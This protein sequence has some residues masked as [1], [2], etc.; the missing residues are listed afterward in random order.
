MAMT[1]LSSVKRVQPRGR[2]LA[3]VLTATLMLLVAPAGAWVD[4]GEEA[5]GP[6]NPHGGYVTDGSFFMSVGELQ[7]NIT[8]WGLIG[9]R[10]SNAATYSDAP[11]AQ[12]PAGSG[13]EY[14]WGAGLWVGGV[15]L[16]E[17]LV[18]T[19]QYE[20][21]IRAQDNVEDTIYEAIGSV[22]TRPFGFPDASGRRAP[23]PAPNDD[24]DTDDLGVPR[25]DEEILNGYDDDEDG[26]LEEDFG[27]VG[28]Q[29]MVTTMYDNTR[30]AAEIFAD[31]SPLNLRI[32]QESFAWENDLVDDFV[33]FQYTIT[34]VG[35]TDIRNVYI[36]FFADPDI[37]PRSL[38]ATASDDMAGSFA[39][40]IKASDGSWVP[41]EVGFMWDAAEEQRLDGYFGIAFL[42][43]DVDPSGQTAPQTIGLRT[44]QRFSGQAPFAQ[45]GDPT[46]DAERYEL[47]SADRED[48]DQDV[49]E[50]RQDDF[51]FL[52][53]AGPFETLSPN[54]ELKFQ[55]AIVLGPG[56]DGMLRN[57]AEAALT[58]YG[59]FFDVL[60]DQA[61]SDG[62]VIETG[63]NGRESII[64][65]ED[66]GDPEDF[67]AIYPDFGDQSCASFQYLQEWPTIQPED[68]FLTTVG[69]QIKH[70]AMV[71]MDNCF[72]CFRQKPHSPNEQPE[73]ARCDE[74]DLDT[75]WNCWDD[76]VGDSQKAGCT[77]VGGAETQVH[78]LVGMAPPPPGMRLWPT[79]S[80]VHVYWD[81]TSESIPDVRLRVIDFESY[82]V[83]RAD[84]WTRPFGTS[85]ETGPGSNLWQLIAEYDIVDSFIVNYPGSGG[86]SDTLPLGRNTGLEVIEYEPV[87]LS[88]PEYEGL[89]DAMQEVVDQDSMGFYTERPPIHDSDGEVVP[90]MEGLLD[91]EDSP[92][93]LDTFWAVTAREEST[94]YDPETERDVV[95]IEGKAP[96]QFY[97]YIDPFVHNGFLYFYSVTATDHALELI[98]GTDPAEFRIV[99]P[100]QSGDP[101]SSFD[102]SSPATLAQSA[103]DRDQEGVNIFVYPN[104]AT[105]SSLAEFQEMNPSGDDPTGVRVKFANLPAAHNTIQIFT[106]SGDLVETIEHDGTEGY[107]EAGWNLISRNGQEVV[108]GLYLYVVKSD[109]DSFEDFIGKFV[110]V[111]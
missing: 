47:M 4:L 48:W 41:V 67:D 61:G 31:H 56:L 15:L 99:G 107:G 106:L 83:W 40:S 62:S 22:L 105:R 27:Q 7:I 76:G 44:F 54:A 51:R 73:Q 58:W 33:G 78:W 39:G 23:E 92:D 104:P 88:D 45:G 95:V 37:G 93:V 86:V 43:H 20:T 50:G 82:R 68:I 29:M 46:N 96:T 17:R 16:G 59:N 77:G 11:S 34:N 25:I 10:Y 21:E 101:S 69:G 30:I 89:D 32:V 60:K 74:S 109:D 66:F 79:E 53:S 5:G 65:R 57:C 28:N 14:L 6:Y 64:C 84:N 87:V 85:V 9:S 71:N 90:G 81:D 49:Q 18:S 98:E 72:E 100:G 13:N 24:E 3:L 2:F 12:W 38:G 42:G 111:R 35:V 55:V 108:S 103:A 94:Y 102:N 75:Y 19:G 80:R 1:L 26:L 63:V 52:V 97:E 91:W 8:N 70:C 110:V 36:G